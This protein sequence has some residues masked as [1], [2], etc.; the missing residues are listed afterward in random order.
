M[1][2]SV[3]FHGNSAQWAGLFGGVLVDELA[4]E[5]CWYRALGISHFDQGRILRRVQAD[6]DSDLSVPVV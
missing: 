3:P 6:L 4:D 1:V 2:G 5:H